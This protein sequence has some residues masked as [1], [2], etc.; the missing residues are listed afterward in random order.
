M[1]VMAKI[2]TGAFLNHIP[3]HF[4]VSHKHKLCTNMRK[5]RSQS[6]VEYEY[7]PITFWLP[8]EVD[9]FLAFLN[10]N[11]HFKQVLPPNIFC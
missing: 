4:E 1:K 6:P 8:S 2:K 5:A 11:P 7:V 10:V 3:R 9:D